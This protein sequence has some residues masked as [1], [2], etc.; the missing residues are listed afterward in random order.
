LAREQNSFAY[1][2]TTAQFGAHLAAI[3]ALR[4]GTQD[5]AVCFDDGHASQYRYAFPL[6]EQYGLKAIFFCVSGRVD[7]FHD[8]M[9]SVQLRELLACGHQ[10]QSHGMTHCM[11]T[12]CPPRQLSEELSGSR[13]DLEQRLGVAV[14]AISIP[15]GRWNAGVLRACAAAGY[16]QVYTSD[17]VPFPRHMQGVEVLGRFIVRNRSG[18]FEIERAVAANAAD[19]K[20]QRASEFG[21]RMARLLVGESLYHALWGMMRSRRALEDSSAEYE[22]APEP[23]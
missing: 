8:A 15:F 14:Q 4:A 3:A 17:P 9:S 7:Y 11:L 1:S 16:L 19:F 2:V 23:R 22:R 5:T 20:L 10:V 12:R 18:G 6:L 21:K 13:R